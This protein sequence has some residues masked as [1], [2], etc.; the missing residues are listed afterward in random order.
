MADPATPF[1]PDRKR[2]TSLFDIE[3]KLSDLNLLNDL[4]VPLFDNI[5]QLAAI[6]CDAPIA[7]ISFFDL[8]LQWIKSGAEMV[9]TKT[10]PIQQSLC[11]A[12]LQNNGLTEIQDTLLNVASA[13]KKLVTSSLAVRF[14]AGVPIVMPDGLTLGTLSVMDTRPRNLLDHQSALLLG[15]AEIIS[16]NLLEKELHRLS[17]K[18]ESYAAIIQNMANQHEYLQFTIDSIGNAVITT[19]RNGLIEYLNPIAQE[20]TG[21]SQEEALG[22]PISK[23]LNIVHEGTLLPADNPVEQC[24]REKRVVTMS[25]HTTL[26]SKSGKHF[27]IH[28]SAAPIKDKKEAVVGAVLVFQD[29]TALREKAQEVNYRATHDVLTGLINRAEFERLV[30]RTRIDAFE[31]TRAHA[32]IYLDLDQFKVVNDTFGHIVGDQ[33]LKEV[34]AILNSC[35]RGSDVCARL[36]GDEFGLLLEACGDTD[37]AMRVAQLICQKIDKYRFLFNGQRFNVSASLGLVLIDDHWP[38]VVKIMQAG[39]SACYA[40]KDAGR[41]RVHLYFDKDYAIET[42]RGEMQWATRLVQAIEDNQFVLFCQR[43]MPLSGKGGD[44]GEVLLRLKDGKGGLL[45][46]GVF[47]PAAERFHLASKIDRWVV[48]ELFNWM[49]VHAEQLAHMDSISVNLS[50]QSIS[51]RKFHS[52]VQDLIQT[53]SL[54]CS[55]LCFEITETAAITNLAEANA[56]IES[57]RMLGVKFSLDDFGSGVSSFGYL[58]HLSVDFLKIDGQFI[59]DLLDNKIDQATVKCINEVAKV[60]G[61]KTI[62]EWVEAESVESL[63]RDIGIDYS[64]GYLRH[65]PAPLHYMLDLHCSYSQ[66]LN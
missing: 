46:P 59:R 62:A 24:L 35:I 44:H 10:I 9:G 6:V 2:L 8:D 31:K 58:K 12:T 60:T 48:T 7:I 38:N 43:I 30:E 20:L 45:T 40:A 23:V 41:N 33:M 36:G 64:Q 32:L 4:A 65:K 18:R 54:D 15:L 51:D 17:S 56:F 29:V 52:F 5:T 19:N 66:A 63:L 28:E 25:H 26:I 42:R 61:K 49:K 21:W 1:F 37:G 34:V 22:C 57:M 27:G 39:E 50:G 14:Y 16:A 13:N 3:K 47:L 11:Q 55:K 53:L